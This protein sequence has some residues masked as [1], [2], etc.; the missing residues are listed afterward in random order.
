MLKSI[1]AVLSGDAIAKKYDMEKEHSASGGHRYL[2]KVYDGV[3]R[4]SKFPVSIFVL[5]KDNEQI[6]SLSKTEKEALI[7]S[8]RKEIAILKAFSA[9][10]P[11]PCPYVLRLFEAIEES[12]KILAF[13]TERVHCSLGNLLK[14]FTNLPMDAQSSNT[15]GSLLTRNLA[16]LEITR[17]SA[18]I[19]ETLQFASLGCHPRYLSPD[20]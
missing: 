13:V 14:D 4:K 6:K 19:L 12:K 20:T 10:K 8:F 3:H 17:G 2:W 1:T 9:A 15:S 5:E 16:T 18:Q 7:E 11:E